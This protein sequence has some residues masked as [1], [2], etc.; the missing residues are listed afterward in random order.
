[1]P[2]LLEDASKWQN[3]PVGMLSD[4]IAKFLPSATIESTHI[5]IL[6]SSPQGKISVQHWQY[7]QYMYCSLTL[8]KSSRPHV[9]YWTIHIHCTSSLVHWFKQRH[10][11]EY[12]LHLKIFLLTSLRKCSC[13][14]PTAQD[15]RAFT[16]CRWTEDSRGANRWWPRENSFIS[17]HIAS[18][19]NKHDD[20]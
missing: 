9:H 14:L 20:L 5:A 7:A 6:P 12:L 4:Y 8:D 3:F 2:I 17:D 18:H 16:T 13:L 19:C 10:V 1:M 11:H 15:T